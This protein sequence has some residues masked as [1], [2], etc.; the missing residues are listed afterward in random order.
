MLDDSP[1]IQSHRRAGCGF[2]PTAPS[3]TYWV[4]EDERETV[5]FGEFS[6]PRP[7]SGLYFFTRNG[8]A[9]GERVVIIMPQGISGD[10]HVRWRDDAGR[11]AIS[12]LRSFSPTPNFQGRARQVTASASAGVTCKSHSQ[13]RSHRRRIP[14]TKWLGHGQPSVRKQSC[15]GSDSAKRGRRRNR[16][17]QPLIFKRTVSPLSSTSA[18]TTGLQKGV[19]LTHGAVL[20]QIRASI[21]GY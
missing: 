1:R 11:P 17:P 16:I 5:T 12:F 9:I 6:C 18:G 13:S 7:P 2:L 10:D 8:V 3:S 20:R 19:A 14:P 4:D 21:P 15:C